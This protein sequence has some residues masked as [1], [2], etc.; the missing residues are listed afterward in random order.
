M[1]VIRTNHFIYITFPYGTEN[2][3][4]VFT[5]Q[6][7]KNSFFKKEEKIVINQRAEYLQNRDDIISKLMSICGCSDEPCRSESLKEAQQIADAYIGVFVEKANCDDAYSMRVNGQMEY[8]DS[9][10]GWMCSQC[11]FFVH[12]ELSNLKLNRFIV[13]RSGYSHTLDRFSEINHNWVTVFWGTTS[14]QREI[15]NSIHFDAWIRKKPIAFTNDEHITLLT[16]D[17]GMRNFIGTKIV[18][19]EDI[20]GIFIRRNGTVENVNNKG[21]FPR[22]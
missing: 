6:N 19:K 14:L 22:W 18:K 5:Y 2:G 12:K 16:N 20:F 3:E 7:R 8:V 9:H 13:Q 1:L 11:T 21:F 17:M 10:N 4:V 15:P